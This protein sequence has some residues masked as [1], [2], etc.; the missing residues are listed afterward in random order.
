MNPAPPTPHGRLQRERDGMRLVE[1]LMRDAKQLQLCTMTSAHA[2]QLA[3]AVTL[4][5]AVDPALVLPSAES[6]SAFV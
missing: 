4:G 1:K 6:Q 2:D 3:A 5:R